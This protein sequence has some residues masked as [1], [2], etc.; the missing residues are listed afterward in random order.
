M[1]SIYVQDPSP[2]A[3]L[4]PVSDRIAGLCRAVSDERMFLVVS[5][6]EEGLDPPVIVEAILTQDGVVVRSHA[7]DVSDE[8]DLEDP[9]LDAN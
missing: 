3:G 2:S 4:R 8:F 7:V 5:E 1:G 6:D 9:S